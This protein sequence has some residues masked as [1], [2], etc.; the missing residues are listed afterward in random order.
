MAESPRAR[1]P[2][3]RTARAEKILDVTR[4][5]LLRLG[6]RRTT[7]DDVAKE[8]GIGKGTIYLH[9]RTREALFDAVFRREAN[10][11]A[12]DLVAAMRSD[13]EVVLLSRQARMFVST[14]LRRPLLRALV[15]G[16]LEIIGKI[17]ADTD[18]VL[19][20]RQDAFYKQY[21]EVLA[22]HGLIR[23]AFD[24]DELYFVYQSVCVGFVLSESLFLEPNRVPAD[25][26]VEL[27]GATVQQA[28]EPAD[29]PSPEA[30]RA[31]AARSID[32]F[33]EMVDSTR[34]YLQS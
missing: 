34:T 3:A 22:E 12:A 11:A 10:E 29:P 33:Q 18:A 25:R 6:Y 16:D 20:G 5:L 32:I 15:V 21:L 17:A 1:T 9:W 13:P 26:M 4:D 14:L 24:T 8:A 23:T 19:E 30:V 28:F 2:E 31:A 27:L 7:I